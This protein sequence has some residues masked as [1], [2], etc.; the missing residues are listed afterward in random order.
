MLGSPPSWGMV[1]SELQP[2]SE[3]VDVK[4]HVHLVLMS[5]T[6][7]AASGV[8]ARA[9][10]SSKDLVQLR[11]VPPSTEANNDTVCFWPGYKS[12]GR[13]MVGS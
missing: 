13:G 5:L 4:E 2:I 10:S 9:A 3:G 6:L 11:P 7:P 12:S 8:A 1:D